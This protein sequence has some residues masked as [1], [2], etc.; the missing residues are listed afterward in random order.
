MKRLSL[1]WL[2]CVAIAM[3]ATA[4]GSSVVK[5]Q[6]FQHPKTEH[7]TGVHPQAIHPKNTEH[8]AIHPKN[9]QIKS[10]HEHR[11]NHS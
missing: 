2:L 1:S 5:H 8:E 9:T 10:K 6:K 3:P 4:A 7:A 11:H